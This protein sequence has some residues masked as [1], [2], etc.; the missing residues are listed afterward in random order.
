MENIFSDLKPR[1]I[2]LT[3]RVNEDENREII[4]IGKKQGLKPA[5]IASALI[6]Y[7]LAIYKKPEDES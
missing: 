5:A 7:A 3:T 6:R 2:V 1:K 4:A